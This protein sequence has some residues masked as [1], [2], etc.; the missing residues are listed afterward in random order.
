MGFRRF[1]I[2]SAIGGA[3]WASGVTVLGYY[4]GQ[5]SFVRN[6]LEAMLLAIVLISVVPIGI[7][8]L[9]SRAAAKVHDLKR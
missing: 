5:V 4:L 7:E 1:M 3:V 2:Y 8:Y 6:N 9:R